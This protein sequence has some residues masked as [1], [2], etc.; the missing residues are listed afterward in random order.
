L[1][2]TLRLLGLTCAFTAVLREF[3]RSPPS[4]TICALFSATYATLSPSPILLC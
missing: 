1:L 4:I 2:I 3:E